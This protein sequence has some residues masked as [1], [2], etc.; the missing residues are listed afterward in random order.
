MDSSK[1][2]ML[3]SSVGARHRKLRNCWIVE[4]VMEV[5]RTIVL[6]AIDQLSFWLTGVFS[7]TP[8]PEIHH[9]D[10]K[11][12]VLGE[13]DDKTAPRSPSFADESL[14]STAASLPL[15]ARSGRASP[16][17]SPVKRKFTVS[18]QM[19]RSSSSSSS[20]RLTLKFQQVKRHAAPQLNN[21]RW[22]S[23]SG[24]DVI[25]NRCADGFLAAS[26]AWC[27]YWLSCGLYVMLSVCRPSVNSRFF[28][29]R[30]SLILMKLGM[31]DVRATDYRVT[32][33]IMNL[34]INIF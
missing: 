9:V 24:S 3:F 20:P 29:I 13:R 31:N 11:P 34:C 26:V 22:R 27:V 15:A 21:G 25:N 12:V 6:T 18:R 32:E 7:L 17:P 1:L 23:T 5:K 10:V 28:S 4:R 16:S 30:L 8:P 14:A 19:A 2:L 33:R